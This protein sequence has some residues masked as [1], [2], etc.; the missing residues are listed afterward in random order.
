M[1][2][3][4]GEL[5]DLALA[6]TV[7]RRLLY[8]DK[9]IG[10]N[11]PLANTQ[12]GIEE[13]LSE[14]RPFDR[15]RDLWPVLCSS[16]HQALKDSRVDERIL[17]P[18]LKFLILPDPSGEATNQHLE[19]YWLSRV[20]NNSHTTAAI[21]TK[22]ITA[23]SVN[24]CLSACIS[25]VRGHA[26]LRSRAD[27]VDGPSKSCRLPPVSTPQTSVSRLPELNTAKAV[28][29]SR[30]RGSSNPYSVEMTRRGQYLN[31]P[32]ATQRACDAQLSLS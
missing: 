4:S 31:E 32:K 19:A 1:L 14:P 10:S 27:H 23:N 8:F 16:L 5:Q 6:C 11:S 30:H 22:Q 26:K 3:N 25:N 28:H 7:A 9:K 24:S 13:F 17:R 12:E 2:E 15:C 20:S 29:G 21:S 18:F